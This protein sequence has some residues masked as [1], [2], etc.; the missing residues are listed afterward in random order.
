MKTHYRHRT[1]HEV[2]KVMSNMH[3]L[4]TIPFMVGEGGDG[5]TREG[6][7]NRSML[8]CCP[9]VKVGGRGSRFQKVRVRTQQRF[10]HKDK[11]V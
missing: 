2:A 4:I 7:E 10:Q 8:M 1:T 6:C 11:I 9:K 5:K 3:S